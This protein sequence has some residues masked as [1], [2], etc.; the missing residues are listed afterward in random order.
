MRGSFLAGLQGSD[1]TRAVRRSTCNGRSR[2]PLAARTWGGLSGLCSGRPRSGSG[3]PP[4]WLAGPNWSRSTGS[5]GPRSWAGLAAWSLR[6]RSASGLIMAAAGFAWFLGALAP[7]AV[8]LQGP[9]AHLIPDVSDGKA[10]AV[11]AT[12][13]RCDR[14]GVRLRG[15]VPDRPQRLRPCISLAG[16][17]AL[18]TRRYVAA[19]GPERRAP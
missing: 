2:A 13:P 8:Y 15:R 9:L 3:S 19:G 10:R 6:P 12:V 1:L 17:A 11:V 5:L 7:W 18:A 16:L 14:R 4:S